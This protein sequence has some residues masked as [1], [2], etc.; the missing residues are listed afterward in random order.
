VVYDL[1]ALRRIRRNTKVRMCVCVGGKVCVCVC[2]WKGED[3]CVC[4]LARV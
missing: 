3:V 2:V 4:V 1:L